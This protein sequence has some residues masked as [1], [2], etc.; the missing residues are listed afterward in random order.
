MIKLIE[1]TED[2]TAWIQGESSVYGIK[3]RTIYEKINE[4]VVLSEKSLSTII[5][6]EKIEAWPYSG[7]CFFEVITDS[8]EIKTLGVYFW[9]TER[10]M[11]L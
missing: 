1:L 2:G 3:G 11:V 4:E 10:S 5:K 8:G 6:E 7:D 9:K